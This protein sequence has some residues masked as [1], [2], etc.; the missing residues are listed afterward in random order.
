MGT[1]RRDAMGRRVFL[2]SI[3]SLAAARLVGSTAIDAF[4]Q[5]PPSAKAEICRPRDAVC[6]QRAI[7][8]LRDSTAPGAWS[9]AK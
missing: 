2:A 6:S 7:T 5:A 9:F 4:A 8:N 1:E 3:G